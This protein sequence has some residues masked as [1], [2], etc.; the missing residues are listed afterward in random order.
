MGVYRNNETG[1]Y[2]TL[3]SQDEK[4]VCHFVNDG[5]KTVHTLPSHLFAA[6]YT[7]ATAEQLEER[8]EAAKKAPKP[9]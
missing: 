4:S 2:V 9:A 6:Q 1:K 7:G 8:A 3:Q 5:Q